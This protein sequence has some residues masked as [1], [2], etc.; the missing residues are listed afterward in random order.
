MKILITGGNGF[1]GRHIAAGAVHRRHKVRIMVRPSAESPDIGP[2]TVEI[3]Q[4]DIRKPMDPGCMAGIDA[5]IHCAAAMGGD[6]ETQLAL[7]VQGTKNLLGGMKEAGLRHIVCLSTFALYDYFQMP[8]GSLLDEDSPLEER[9]QSRSPYIRA[10]RQQED[11]VREVSGSN[12]WRCTIFRP[13]IVYGK[14][15]T[16]FHHLGMQLSA[17]RW[18][19]LAEDSLLPLTY[20]ENCAKAILDGLESETANGQTLNIVDDSLPTRRAYMEAL[21][22]RTTPRPGISGIPW[23]FLDSASRTAAWANRTLLSGK[24]SLPDLLSPAS[25]HARCKPLH[26]SN[27]RAKRILRWKPDSNW[28]D[29]LERSL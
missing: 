22:S 25:L 9:L 21:A 7:T 10:K 23:A 6:L 18:V 19:C 28:L 27:E 3:V 20:V 12:G 5:V 26:Y 14:G 17:R 4:Q 29:C 1:I 13:G 15:R 11:L 24:V 16:W 8:A 2:S